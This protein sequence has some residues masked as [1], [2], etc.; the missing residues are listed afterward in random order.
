MRMKTGL[1][2]AAAAAAAAAVALACAAHA[3]PEQSYEA[4]KKMRDLAVGKDQSNVEDRDLERRGADLLKA[5]G[6]G[7]KQG[8]QDAIKG[9]RGSEN[10]NA[11]PG[12]QQA[13]P[14]APAAGSRDTKEREPRDN[15]PR[16]RSPRGGGERNDAPHNDR[17]SRTA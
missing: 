4:G 17:V 2:L 15:G 7:D 11:D 1:I 5:L 16:D 3:D 14:S 13:A 6:A 9:G 10:R 8:V 12:K